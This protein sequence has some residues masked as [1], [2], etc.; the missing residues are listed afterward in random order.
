LWA[1][2]GHHKTGEPYWDG[3]FLGLRLGSMSSIQAHGSFIDMIWLIICHKLW[4][5]VTNHR[6][7]NSPSVIQRQ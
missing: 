2:L 4:L 5:G 1:K 6:T 7:I 3:L